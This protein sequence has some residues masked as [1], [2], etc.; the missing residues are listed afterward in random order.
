MPIEGLDEFRR[1]A[2]A[3]RGADK[4]VMSEVGRSMRAVAKPIVGEIRAEVRSSKGT[5]HRGV[6]ASEVERQLHA[7]GRAG[8]RGVRLT[9]RQVASLQKRLAKV[10]GLRDSIAAAS[11]SSVAA[12]D[13]KVE[14]AFKVRASQLPPSQRKLPRRW[15]AEGGWKHPVYGNRNVWVRQVGHPYFRKTI[16]RNRDDVAAGVVT[17][18][19]AAAEKILHSDGSPV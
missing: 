18:M 13:R 8:R 17:A 9:E 2:T 5:S 7:L 14:L 15:D 11:G 4:T 10:T 1:A 6:R 19:S 12:G 3:L 16:Y